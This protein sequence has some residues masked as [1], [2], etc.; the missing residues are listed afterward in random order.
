MKLIPDL[1]VETAFSQGIGGHQCFTSANDIPDRSKLAGLLSMAREEERMQGDSYLSISRD[2]TQSSSGRDTRETILLYNLDTSKCSKE[3]IDDLYQQLTELFDRFDELQ[4]DQPPP[5]QGLQTISTSPTLQRW[6]TGIQGIEKLSVYAVPNLPTPARKKTSWYAPTSLTGFTLITGVLIVICLAILSPPAEPEDS[7]N[8]ENVTQITPNSERKPEI[9]K[10]PQPAE[11]L[12]ADSLLKEI[13][14]LRVNPTLQSIRYD[15]PTLHE[16]KFNKLDQE[17]RGQVERAFHD[18]VIYYFQTSA[19]RGLSQDYVDLLDAKQR[20]QVVMPKMIDR[21]MSDEIPQVIVQRYYVQQLQNMRT[22]LSMSQ[23]SSSLNIPQIELETTTLEGIAAANKKFLQ[24]RPQIEKLKK[25]YDLILHSNVKCR[26]LAM[27][28]PKNKN[29]D[30]EDVLIE[31]HGKKT[32]GYQSKIS[33]L[34]KIDESIGTNAKYDQQKFIV[35]S[36]VFDV[37]ITNLPKLK[38]SGL[39]FVLHGPDNQPFP[40]LHLVSD[41]REKAEPHVKSKPT[42]FGILIQTPSPN[43]SHFLMARGIL[44]RE[45]PSVPVEVFA[46]LEFDTTVYKNIEQLVREIDA[47]LQEL[48]TTKN[49]KQS[50]K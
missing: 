41:P 47:L 25:D 18:L 39:R 30:L 44:G 37:S 45:I 13:E 16:D 1:L 17:Q 24:A 2:A 29:T 11:N 36:N 43:S 49:Q 10:K 33:Y 46:R 20:L 19:G 26:V 23:Q 9:E 35:S 22:S 15:F 42:D 48:Q 12:V 34:D 6:L 32:W 7:K 8:S 38:E 40:V 3:G 14:N 31:K 28:S 50:Q 27:I 5:G 4:A 21:L